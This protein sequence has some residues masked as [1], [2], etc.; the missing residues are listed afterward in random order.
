MKDA[1]LPTRLYWKGDRPKHRGLWAAEWFFLLLGLAALDTYLWVNTSTL[2][3]QAYA[4]W[5]FDEKLRGLE[6]AVSGFVA[7]EIYWLFGGER[8]KEENPEVPRK[9]EP[10][11]PAQPPH[12]DMLLGRLRIPRLHVA[13]MVREG[14]DSGTLRRAIGH[15]PGTAL[16]GKA[17]NVA[18]AG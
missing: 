9:F 5:A 3:Y 11:P 12:P 15:I 18:L 10:I 4:D 17:G 16:P 6:P 14:A 1:A 7:D 2:L 13:A 8:V